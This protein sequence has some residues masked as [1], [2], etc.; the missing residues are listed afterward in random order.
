MKK[1]RFPDCSLVLRDPNEETK[2]FNKM[3]KK[4]INFRGFAICDLFTD[5]D[6]LQI[7]SKTS[8]EQFFAVYYGGKCVGTIYWG[9]KYSDDDM[10]KIKKKFVP[11]TWKD[12]NEYS[13][14]KEG[15]KYLKLGTDRYA[16][17]YKE[18]LEKVK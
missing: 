6:V 8:K 9:N 12:I 2:I 18:I 13:D 15:V 5:M 11:P 16:W 14:I 7:S 10:L 1:N 17:I 3:E 4:L